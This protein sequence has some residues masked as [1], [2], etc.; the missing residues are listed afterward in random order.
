MSL[1]TDIIAI[2]MNQEDQTLELLLEMLKSGCNPVPDD[3]DY[4]LGVACE[5]LRQQIER[6]KRTEDT[7][8][9]PKGSPY[10]DELRQR[11]ADSKTKIAAI[12]GTEKLEE[13]LKETLEEE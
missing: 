3:P 13:I 2:G 5:T 12:V 7:C 11:L 9:W 6:I 1:H 8:A 10:L 4:T